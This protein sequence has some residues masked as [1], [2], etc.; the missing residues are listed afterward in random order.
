MTDQ[1][2]FFS[3]PGGVYE[4]DNYTYSVYVIKEGYV[5]CTTNLTLTADT[6]LEI[7]LIKR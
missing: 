4:S 3:I 1:N 7:Q 2:G 6:K 5:T